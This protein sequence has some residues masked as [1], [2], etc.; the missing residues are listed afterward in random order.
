MGRGGLGG[1]LGA[2]GRGVRR[3]G[4]GAQR[5]GRLLPRGRPQW[6]VAAEAPPGVAFGAGAEWC[7]LGSWQAGHALPRSGSG[8]A[9]DLPGRGQLRRARWWP[10]RGAQR[11]YLGLQCVPR[12]WGVRT[13][14]DQ[15]FRGPRRQAPMALLGVTVVCGA[16]VAGGLGPLPGPA[17]CSF[18]GHAARRPRALGPR[19]VAVRAGPRAPGRRPGRPLAG[20]GR[21]LRLPWVRPEPGWW[22]TLGKAQMGS[23]P[24]LSLARAPPPPSNFPSGASISQPCEQG[25]LARP[26]LGFGACR[27]QPPASPWPAASHRTHSP[28]Q[29]CPRAARGRGSSLHLRTGA[30][31]SRQELA[32]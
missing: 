25:S 32:S 22:R 18:Q 31:G 17:G 28:L 26:S 16:G 12:K 14:E 7:G 9:A 1:S 4:R 29:C 24:C 20:S 11:R 13:P 5:E 23:L 30:G 6:S 21:G 3:P 10:G 2:A 15:D 8:S 27:G 19:P